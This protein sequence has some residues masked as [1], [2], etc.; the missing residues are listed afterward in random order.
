MRSFERGK[1]ERQLDHALEVGLGEGV[2]YIVERFDVWL[3]Y[4]VLKR[5]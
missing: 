1:G 2:W 5:S 3:W 4:D